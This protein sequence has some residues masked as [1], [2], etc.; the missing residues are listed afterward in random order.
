MSVLSFLFWTLLI[1]FMNSS[2]RSHLQ[3]VLPIGHVS[4]CCFLELT[5]DL[6]WSYFYCLSSNFHI[7]HSQS[8]GKNLFKLF[9]SCQLH[10]SSESQAA[11]PL[12]LLVLIDNKMLTVLHH[13]L[14]DKFNCLVHVY[15]FQSC[16]KVLLFIQCTCILVST[17]FIDRFYST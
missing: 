4:H 15:G 13:N 6:K 9:V 5:N 17:S 8:M 10:F 2:H 11:V 16:T 14:F 3:M 1:L 7:K 12:Y